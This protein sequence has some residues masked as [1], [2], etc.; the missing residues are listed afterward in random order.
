MGKEEKQLYKVCRA[1]GRCFP[2]YLEYYEQLGESYPVYPNF[3]EHP[4][5]TDKGRPFALSAQESCPHA[6]PNAP[7][8]PAPGDCGGCGWFHRGNTP[9]DPIGVCLCDARRREIKS[10]EEERK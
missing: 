7:G 8:K 10:E 2:I 3:T 6:R 1:G 5:Y 4:E 9:Y